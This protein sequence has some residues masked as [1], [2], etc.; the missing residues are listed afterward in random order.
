MPIQSVAADPHP[1][2]MC[3][4]LR[5][6]AEKLALWCEDFAECKAV[7]RYMAVYENI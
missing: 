4:R 3:F 2:P 7:S 1:D 6:L 5:Q